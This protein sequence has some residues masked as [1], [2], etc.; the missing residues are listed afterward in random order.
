MSD[1]TAINYADHTWSPWQGCTMGCEYCYAARLMRRWGH[2]GLYGPGATPRVTADSGWKKPLTWNR[3]AAKEGRRHSVLLSM[4]DPFEPHAVARETWPRFLTLIDATP[5][6]DWLLLTKRYTRVRPQMLTVNPSAF[7]NVWIGFTVEGYQWFP[8]ARGEQMMLGHRGWNT[9]Y[10][11][12]PAT[13]DIDWRLI[14]PSMGNRLPRVVICGGMSGPGAV[15]M[16]PNWARAC[17]DACVKAG[18]LFYF[19]QWGDQLR[20]EQIAAGATEFAPHDGRV[21][22]GRIHDELPWGKEII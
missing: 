6:L 14:H 19:K 20:A 16:P 8:A 5:N 3:K 13:A 21:L 1:K 22:D 10:S 2:A 11:Y 18:V 17:R 4:C 12:E 7:P 15:P 9:W